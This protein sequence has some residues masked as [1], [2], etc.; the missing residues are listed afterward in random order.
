VSL[1]NYQT[2]ALPVASNVDELSTTQ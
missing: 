2:H 1:C